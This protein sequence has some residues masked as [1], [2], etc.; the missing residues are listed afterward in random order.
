MGLKRVAIL[1]Y[2]D[3]KFYDRV[4]KKLDRSGSIRDRALRRAAG[5][6]PVSLPDPDAARA[7]LEAV[8]PRPHP[9]ASQTGFRNAATCDVSVI[10]PVYNTEAYLG[11]C[12]D[13]LTVQQGVFSLEIVVVNDGSTDGSLQIARDRAEKDGRIRIIE[14]ENG[15][16]SSARNAGILESRGAC[17][18]FVDSDDMLA[19][20]HLANLLAALGDARDAFVSGVFTR[21]LE[22]G[23]VLGP[24]E[25]VRTHGGACG[26]LYPR[27]LWADVRFPEGFLFEDTAIAYCIKP[28]FHEIPA[29]DAG[30]LRRGRPGSITASTPASPRAVESYWIVE[31]MLDRCRDL[32]IPLESV[33][34]QTLVQFGPLLRD[35]C[36]SLDAP[37]TRALFALSAHTY[38]SVPAWL[39]AT[40]QGLATHLH[41]ALAEKNYPLWLACC[42][43][44]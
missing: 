9:S 41:R 15:G 14:K 27:E 18:S 2:A 44:L 13:S 29:A 32:G 37:A 39:A 19:P 16:L 34:D 25:R 23:R 43:W 26:R 28:R 21:M 3:A 38:A 31:E 40:P 20:D 7:T 33:R 42:R 35:R 11:D 36:R 6:P 10:V 5:Q 30:Y 1:G 17:L 8:S 24:Y 4:V 22:S 12:L